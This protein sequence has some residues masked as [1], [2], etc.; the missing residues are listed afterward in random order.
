M[1]LAS[2]GNDN[3]LLIWRNGYNMPQQRFDQ[4]TAAVKVSISMLS[5]PPSRIGIIWFF[6]WQTLC[7]RPPHLLLFGNKSPRG[8]WVYAWMKH[9]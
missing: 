3:R 4:H 7:R 9:V 6:Y 5:S 1:H 8:A 2:G